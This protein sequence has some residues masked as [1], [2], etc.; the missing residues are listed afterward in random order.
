MNA[1]TNPEI[2]K[3]IGPARIA[4]FFQDFTQGLKAA[5]LAPPDPESATEDYINSAAALF[6]SPALPA[7]APLY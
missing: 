2:L 3:Q 5:G 6:A 4:R 7:P 1:F